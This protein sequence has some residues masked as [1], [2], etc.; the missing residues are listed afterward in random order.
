MT[1]KRLEQLKGFLAA[2]PNEPFILFAIAKEYEGLEDNK[3]ALDYY[4][5][6]EQN[7]PEYVGTYYHLGKL[8]EHLGEDKKAFFTYKKGMSIAK[9]AGDNHS[10][11]ELA[12]AKMELGDDD[13]FED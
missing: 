1:T 4:L 6:L 10:L 12:G 8:Y 9:E 2:S 5:Q 7:S 11:S 3:N 13:D